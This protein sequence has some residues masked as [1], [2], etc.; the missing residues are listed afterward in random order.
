MRKFPKDRPIVCH[1]EGQTLGCLLSAAQFAQRSG[2]LS[3]IMNVF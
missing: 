2:K 1:A 3:M